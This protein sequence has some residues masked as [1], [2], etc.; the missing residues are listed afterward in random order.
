VKN[1]YTERELLTAL[2][3][4]YTAVRRGTIADRWVRAEHV[5]RHVGHSRKGLTRIA[6]F[7]AIDTYPG[8]PYGASLAIHGHEIKVSR[9]DWLRERGH[10]EKSEP[11]RQY[12]HFWWLVVSAPEVV[13]TDELP[14]GWGLMVLSKGKLRAKIAP[15]RREPSALPLDLS[16]SIASAAA[17]TASRYP[18][19]LDAPKG[20]KPSRD[21][22][23]MVD[24]CSACGSPAPCAYHQ[25]RAH[26]R[27]LEA[28]EQGRARWAS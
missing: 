22:T 23:S 10:P 9:S 14:D 3:A 7:I 21:L 6:D 1:A 11:I 13:K 17:R 26:A 4:R 28:R 12:C 24:L 25:P 20:G 16:V 18:L 27:E 19:Y 2:N 5:K 8:I 15:A